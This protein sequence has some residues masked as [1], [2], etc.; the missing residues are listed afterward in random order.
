L[1]DPSRAQAM[2]KAGRQRVERLF[3]L[4]DT[5]SITETLYEQLMIERFDKGSTT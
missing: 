5:I 1:N 4:A 2:G 3:N